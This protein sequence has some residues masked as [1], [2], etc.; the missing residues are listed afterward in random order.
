[1]IKPGKYIHFKGNEYEVIGTATHSE[2][3]EEMVVYRALYGDGGVW[4]RPASMWDEVVEYNGRRIKRFT[5]EDEL[6]AESINDIHKNS[7]PNEKV[8]LFLS[9]F[10]GREDVFAK[11]WENTKKGISGY[12]P[13]C[14]NEWSP[15][16]PKTGGNKMKCSDCANQSFVKFDAV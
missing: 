11:R 10:T 9:L 3:L 16:C 2:T 1:M 15:A 14:N 8:E 13:A 5:H 7:T 6:V 4:V 12:V